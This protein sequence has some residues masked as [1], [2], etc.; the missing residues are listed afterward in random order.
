M[1]HGNTWGREWMGKLA[2]CS[3]WP[4]PFTLPRNMVYPALL[5]LM[6]TPRLPAVYWTD[7]PLPPADLNGLVRFAARRNLVSVRVPS[8]FNCTV[9]TDSDIKRNTLSSS[10]PSCAGIWTVT[11]V[12]RPSDEE[13]ALPFCTVAYRRGW[14]GGVQHPLPPEIPKALQNRAKLNPIVKTVKNG[15]I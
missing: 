15:W 3:G 14:F 12:A 5:P 7:A 8:H 9:Q 1:A 6:R 4:V 2:K 10:S 13:R 11:V